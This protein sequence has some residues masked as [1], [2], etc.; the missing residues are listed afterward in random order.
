MEVR[1]LRQED[2]KKARKFV[3][4]RIYQRNMR[5]AFFSL[6]VARISPFT[7][8]CI[9]RLFFVQT[10]SMLSQERHF[11]L[12]AVNTASGEAVL[13]EI[14]E[15][16]RKDDL[17]SNK[18][19]FEIAHYTDTGSHSD[20]EDRTIA[21]V[22]EDTEHVG[23]L[24]LVAD[25]WKVRDM[26]GLECNCAKITTDT[27]TSAYKRAASALQ[28]VNMLQVLV[29]AIQQANALVCQMAKRVQREVVSKGDLSDLL[30]S[31]TPPATCIAVVVNKHIASL[32]HVGWCQ[33]YL[34]R[35][36]QV[37]QISQEHTVAAEMVRRGMLTPQ[38]AKTNRQRFIITHMLGVSSSPIDV[39]TREEPVQDG[40]ILA[41][42]TRRFAEYM[43][44]EELSRMMVPERL[45]ESVQELVRRTRQRFG[46]RKDIN[47]TYLSPLYNFSLMAVSISQ[48]EQEK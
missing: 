38:E 5:M 37:K 34:L 22:P 15:R 8:V 35:E 1:F 32:A 14:K 11:V 23:A 10:A 47:V 28:Q 27:I 46:E 20:V 26:K 19:S 31:G 29:D 25:G 16:R 48:S 45:Q 43:D 4:L 18:F 13:V 42:C 2:S 39:D 7:D 21:L 6:E 40:D 12:Q 44:D 33:A 36:G 41:L 24:F 9:T 3:S 17:M 30:W